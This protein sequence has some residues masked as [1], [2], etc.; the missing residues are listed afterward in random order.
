MRYPITPHWTSVTPSCG[1]AMVCLLI[2][3]G[4]AACERADGPR[5][6][7]YPMFDPV[8]PFPELQRGEGG[9]QS[10]GA[11][12]FEEAIEQAA[13]GEDD[14]QTGEGGQAYAESGSYQNIPLA[15]L[16]VAE[17]PLVFDEWQYV[18][19]NQNTL[20]IHRKPGQVP[21][22]IVYVE[23]FTQAVEAF[24]SYEVARFQFTVDPG[25]SPNAIYPPLGALLLTGGDG[26]Q[27]AEA[28]PFDVAMALQLA[29]TRTMGRGLGYQSSAGSFTG[30][31]WVGH[32]PA[33]LDVRLGRSSGRWAEQKLPV[34]AT[35][36]QILGQYGAQYP[37]L[38]EL[39][40]A[41]SLLDAKA[42]TGRAPGPAWMIVG[43]MARQ[44]N[45]SL[46]VHVAILCE[47]RPVCPVAKELSH[48]LESTRPLDDAGL[49][50]PPASSDFTT[51]ATEAGI[52]L[53]SPQQMLSAPDLLRLL[54]ADAQQ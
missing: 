33:G 15:S 51:F 21:D 22:A 53:L 46:G 6:A 48:L 3:G 10:S 18:T 37:E 12:S 23:A 7:P 30:W 2:V 26:D 25:L 8:Q 27:G 45:A 54:E 14:L 41:F 9:A 50:A 44:K 47:Q 36:A 17:V 11:E 31:K 52:D 34:G 13:S 4:L 24:P 32:T 42:G 49:L 38:A 16:F 20:L 5:R 35:V 43:S 39:G 1:L 29:T 40:A 28:P 19:D